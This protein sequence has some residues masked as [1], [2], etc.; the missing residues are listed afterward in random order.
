MKERFTRE[1][2][3]YAK[4]ALFP[5]ILQTPHSPSTVTIAGGEIAGMR[6]ISAWII[7][8]QKPFSVNLHNYKIKFHAWRSTF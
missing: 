1:I 2:A 3:T 7:I 6:K 5:F 8:P 4:K